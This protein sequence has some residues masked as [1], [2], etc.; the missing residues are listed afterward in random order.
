MRDFFKIRNLK[1]EKK[2]GP[3]NDEKGKWDS[4]SMKQNIA[5]Y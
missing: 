4:I 3:F 2:V 1:T 5:S